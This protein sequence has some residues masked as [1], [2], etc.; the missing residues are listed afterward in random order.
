MDINAVCEKTGQAEALSSV[1]GIGRIYSPK[2]IMPY[3]FR[4]EDATRCRRF[5]EQEYLLVRNMDEL[6]YLRENNYSGEIIADHTLYTFNRLS[7][8]TLFELGVRQDTAPL[9]LTFHELAKRGMENSELMIYGRVPMMISAG[10]LYRNSNNNKYY[11]STDEGMRM[12]RAHDMKHDMVLTDRMKTDFPV[13]CDCGYCYNIIFN[14]VPVSLHNEM[15][16]VIRLKPASV[17]LYFTTEE[18][19]EAAKTAEDFINLTGIEYNKA[20]TK[21]HFINGID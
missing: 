11:K 20:F 21:G 19:R 1:K 2:N 4:N 10:C 13:L 8:E 9:E 17:R 7:R 12:L 15:E 5:L 3:V 6:G 14:S 18:P 16:R